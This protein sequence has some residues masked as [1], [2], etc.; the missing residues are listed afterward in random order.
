MATHSK[1]STREPWNRGF[2]Y[3]RDLA[4]ISRKKNLRYAYVIVDPQ[5]IAAIGCH[6]FLPPKTDIWPRPPPP[7]YHTH[8]T[9][10]CHYRMRVIFSR[11]V[12]LPGYRLALP[13]L[14]FTA[15][16]GLSTC[17]LRP[18]STR[19]LEAEPCSTYI[20]TAKL[21]LF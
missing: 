19:D 13:P 15:Q 8:T 21:F 14:Q 18:Y 2:Q 9:L 17:C 16:R 10:A 7:R 3:I 1:L 4:A 6:T 11:R 5:R 12:W 20:T